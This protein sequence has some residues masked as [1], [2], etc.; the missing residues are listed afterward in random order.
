[1]NSILRYFL[2]I[3]FKNT[4]V[5]TP[6][7]IGLALFLFLLIFSI[8]LKAQTLRF[9]HFTTDD[10]LPENTAQAILQDQKGFIWI[11]TQNGLTRYDA[12]EFITYKHN[13]N[14]SLSLSNNQIQDLFEDSRGFI[15]VATRNGLNRFD[16]N[17]GSFQKYYPNSHQTFGDNWLSFGI[18]EDA[19][20]HIWFCNFKGLYEVQNWTARQINYYPTKAEDEKLISI[21]RDDNGELWLIKGLSIYQ[22]THGKLQLID[23]VH[24]TINDLCQYKENIVVL[25]ENGIYQLNGGKAELII[26]QSNWGDNVPLFINVDRDN[27]LWVGSTNGIYV[28]ENLILVEHYQHHEDLSNSLSHNTA[29]CWIQDRQGLIWIGTSQGLNL[30]DP[31]HLQVWQIN[32]KTASNFRLLDDNINAL[33]FDQNNQFWMAGQKGLLKVK[34]NST[35]KNIESLTANDFVIP[36]YKSESVE[37]FENKNIDCI[38]AL[39][40]GNVLVG[41]VSGELWYWTPESNRFIMWFDGEG[42]QQLR[43]IIPDKNNE[44]L[45][46]GFGNVLYAFNVHTKKLYEPSWYNPIHY[47]VQMGMFRNELWV[48]SNDAIHVLDLEKEKSKTFA[49]N[50]I[51]SKGLTNT[52]ITHTLATDSVLWFSTFGG[53]LCKYNPDSKKFTSFTEL[54]GLANN[55]VWCVYDDKEQN[56]WLSTDNGVCRYNPANGEVLVIDKADGLNFNDFSMKAHC[57]LPFGMLAFGNPK[58]LNI[59]SPN[60]WQSNP[61]PPPVA[62]ST[63]EVNYKA[64]SLVAK[65][66]FLVLEPSDKSLTIHF[67]GLGFRNPQKNKYRIRLKGYDSEWIERTA[68]EANATYTDLPAGNFQFEVMAANSAGIWNKSIAKLAIKVLPPFYKTTWFRLLAFIFGVASIGGLVYWYDHRKHLRAIAKLLTVEKIQNERQRI[69]RDLHDH[70]G[71]HLT[72]VITDLDLLSLKIV[73]LSIIPVVMFSRINLKKHFLTDIIGGLVIGSIIWYISIYHF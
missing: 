23:E 35:F 71:A 67:R 16:P 36:A 31:L 72:K 53:G 6:Q 45:W 33:A 51:D 37:G 3:D 47:V 14:D 68:K 22:F 2:V 73:F 48:G 50:H 5:S 21:H 49:V 70:V 43:N 12:T 61:Y 4:K 38:R 63:I 13:P 57:R 32:A 52:M 54:N 56:L 19:N 64:R 27:K 1:M 17:T 7:F 69:S 26:S 40:N 42:F 65:D 11:G 39:E 9:K 10:G 8:G 46:L 28:F 60:K 55:N 62:I 24:S 20:G 58:G 34:F 59:L 25:A 18:N 15:W 44:T 41:T 30:A 66:R 29:L